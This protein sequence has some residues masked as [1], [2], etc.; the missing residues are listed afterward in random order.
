[1]QTTTTNTHNRPTIGISK[2]CQDNRAH[3]K[4]CEWDVLIQEIEHKWESGVMKEAGIMIVPI[5]PSLV[6]GEVVTLFA[7]DPVSATFL[8]RKGVKESPRKAIRASNRLQPD[9][10][11]AADAIIYTKEKLGADA[12]TGL[13]WELV[14]FR[15]LQDPDQPQHIDSLLPNLF[16]GSGGTE[17]AADK[18]AEQKLKMIEDSWRE[19]QNKA[20]IA[21][22]PTSK[23]VTK[24]TVLQ[25][26]KISGLEDV[27]HNVLNHP[28][29]PDFSNQKPAVLDKLHTIYQSFTE[30]EVQEH[31]NFYSS[32][33]GQAMVEKMPDVIQ[34]VTE[35]FSMF[36]PVQ[37]PKKP[38]TI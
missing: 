29:L 4:N 11:Y 9:P 34:R 2:F 23:P 12:S 19:W 16:G 18:T 10:V 21:Q 33:A 6:K 3:A 22:P 25:L 30:W 1:M 27:I 15:G 31:I 7:G 32:P 36:M 20:I 14:T 37:Y 17:V 28:G 13:D 24:E 26:F 35:L 5:D 8:P 38:G